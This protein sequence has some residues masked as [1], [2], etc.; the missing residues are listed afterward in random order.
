MTTTPTKSPFYIEQGFLS[1]KEV[2]TLAEATHVK[3]QPDGD[4]P[5]EP[6]VRSYKPG[7]DLIFGKL[8]PMI[9]KLEQYFELEYEG[10]ENI[11]FQQFPPNNGKNSEEPQCFNAVYKRKKWVRVNNRALTAI[12]WL[13]D[14]QDQP[15]FN[16]QEQVYGGKLEF[17]VYNFGFQPQ[18]GTLVVYPACERFISLTTSVQVGELQVARIH[19]HA[20]GIWLYNPQLF[21]GDYRSW[22]NYVV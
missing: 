7:E 17:P 5:A 3:L 13:K 1:L 6:L 16:M 18:A 12:I 22:F 2:R 10:T 11:V 21:P 4:A 8:K 15:P 9:P 19:L 14:Y 20:K